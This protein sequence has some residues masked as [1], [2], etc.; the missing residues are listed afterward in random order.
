MA[1]ASLTSILLPSPSA[2]VGL[3]R[4]HAQDILEGDAAVDFFE[5]RGED[6]MGAGGPPHS[7]LRLVRQR[8][9]I[10]VHGAGLSLGGEQRVDRAHFRRLRDLIDRY[11]LC[12]VSEQLGW[13][14][15][16]GV[17][18]SELLP[19]PYNDEVLDRVC[20]RI[21]DVQRTLGAQ[22]LLENPPAY[23][24]FE[25]STMSEVEFL[26]RIVRLTGCSLVLDV[27]HVYVSAINQQFEPMEYVDAFPLEHVRKIHL[28]GHSE[29]SDDDGSRLLI[30]DHGC[31][32]PQVVWALYRRVLARVGPCPTVI[33]WD[34]NIPDFPRL[35]AET[36]LAKDALQFEA[37]RRAR[38]RVA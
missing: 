28:A 7:L 25:A 36:A 23:V 30:D 38:R 29:E 14:M 37:N 35:A 8:Y 34:N 27:G 5:I 11:Q 32:V 16:D 1:P 22:L 10:S 20:N 19:L 33:E 31:A 9:P 12:L 6:Y 15:H 26:R 21:D 2:G 4:Q 17:F 13:S 3:K 18:F 24:A